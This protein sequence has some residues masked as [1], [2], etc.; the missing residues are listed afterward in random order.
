MA[1]RGL[2][3]LT[4]FQIIAFGFAAAILAGALLLCLPLASNAHKATDFL[5]TLFTATSAVCVTGLVLVDTATHWSPFGQFIILLLIQIGGIGVVTVTVTA[6]MAAGRKIDLMQRDMMRYSVSSDRIGGIVQ[7]TRFIVKAVFLVELLG[8]LVLSSVFVPQF[9]WGKGI[10]Y[11]VFHSVS[12]FCNAG[13][14]LMGIKGA[15]SSLTTYAGDPLVNL[16]IMALIIIGG[17][18]FLTWKD[19]LRNH[20]RFRRFKLQ[21][22]IILTATV[23]LIVIPAVL[24]YFF[25]YG[26]A[27]GA[28][29]VWLSVFQSVTTR[30]AGFNTANLCTLSD[31]GI[32]LMIMLM[33]I[34]GSPGST[35]GGMKTTTAAVLMGWLWAA[36]KRERYPEYF[37]RRIAQEAINSAIAILMLYMSL[38]LFGA[39]LISCFDHVPLLAAMFETASAVGTVGL[40]LGLTPTLSSLSHM[41]LILLMFIGRVGGLTLAYAAKSRLETYTASLPTENIMVG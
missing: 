14:D 34:G 31:N 6:V 30:T 36:L 10:W 9:G 27:V 22:K 33:L 13:F 25:E 18:G 41:L 39:M 26:Q 19:I 7:L 8:A 40:S 12:A 4:T 1:R 11:S 2:R 21:T 37:Q 23:F 16:T 32:L 29:R 15:F 17:L 35:A 20:F 24:F 28:K 3:R 5:T 38:F